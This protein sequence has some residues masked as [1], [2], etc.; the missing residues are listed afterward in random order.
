VRGGDVAIDP[1]ELGPVLRCLPHLM[2]NAVDHGIEPSAERG[3]KPQ[4]RQLVLSF[5][6]GAE[7]WDI[8]VTDDGRG[9]DP[10][11]VVDASV[12][13]GIVNVPPLDQLKMPDTLALL[14]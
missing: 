10:K 7:S 1:I 12:C 9:I 5:R 11:R 14:T 4:R 6:D 2:R 13:Q 3:S 8:R